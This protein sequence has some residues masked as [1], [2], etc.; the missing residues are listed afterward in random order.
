VELKKKSIEITRRLEMPLVAYLGDTAKADYMSLPCVRDAK[1]LLIECT[2][3]DP[4]HVRRARAGRHLHVIDLPAVLEGSNNEKIVLTHVT[5]R[6]NMAEAKRILK[7]ALPKAIYERVTF[8]MSRRYI[9]EDDLADPSPP[10]G[11]A[12]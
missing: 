3:F 5:R 4:D 10:K 6:T 1:A 7:K 8:L 2:F 9:E 11:A 12:E